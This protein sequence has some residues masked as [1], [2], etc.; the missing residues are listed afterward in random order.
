MKTQTKEKKEVVTPTDEQ[1]EKVMQKSCCRN[2]C[3]NCERCSFYWECF[4][5]KK[6]TITEWEI[7]RNK[8]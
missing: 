1:V 4:R 3:G 2:E 8:K 7:L 6:T 5:E